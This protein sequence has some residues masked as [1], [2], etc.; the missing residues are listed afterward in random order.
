MLSAT[1]AR[2]TLF[3]LLTLLAVAA[4]GFTFSLA[5]Q[6]SAFAA[7]FAK[8]T[9]AVVVFWV[10]DTYLLP[11]INTTDEIRNGNIAY[12]LFMLALAVV[13]A[14]TIATA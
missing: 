13:V 7:A 5:V 1:K 6:Y 3:T 11:D 2:T 14:A 9:L 4:V 12:G 10:V 8:T